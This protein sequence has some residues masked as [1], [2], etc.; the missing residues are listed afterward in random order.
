VKIVA[1]GPLELAGPEEYALVE[2]SEVLMTSK[3]VSTG[4]ALMGIGTLRE[5]AITNLSNQRQ[6][7]EADTVLGRVEY[8]EQI[9]E[10]ADAV[11]VTAECKREEG[12]G[13]GFDFDSRIYKGP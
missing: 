12:N 4:K 2:P 1:I 7:V 6:W 8:V 3:K 9:V 10:E 11:F 13:E 5:I